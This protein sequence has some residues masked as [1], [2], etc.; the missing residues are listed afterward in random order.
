MSTDVALFDNGVKVPAYITNSAVGKAL[1]QQIAGGLD[2]Q[3]INRVALRNSKFRFMKSGAEVAVWDKPLEAVIVAANPHVGRI[4][5]AK[6]FD[7]NAA[8]ERPDCYSKD[9]RAPEDDSPNKQHDLCAT[10]PKNAKGSANNGVG[11][12]CAYKKRVIIAAPGAINGDKYALDLGAMTMFGD[13]LPAHKLYNFRSYLDVLAANGINPAGVITKFSFDDKATVAK[14][15]CTPVRPLTE[16]EWKQV[17]ATIGDP[18]IA[19]MLDDTDYA[20]EAGKPIAGAPAAVA[21]PA[22]A[23][24]EAPKPRAPRQTKAQQAAPAPAPEPQAAPSAP[25]GFGAPAA[26]PAATAPAG[27]G[28]PAPVAAAPAAPAGFGAPAAAPA[29]PAAGGFI[30]DVEEFED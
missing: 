12:A 10:C 17:E 1:A 6:P 7:Q 30:I 23:P 13:E 18:E 25:A 15:H 11:K 19:K 9:G 24:A 16:A 3:S 26:A 29:Q 5:Y 2:G 20:S 8:A 28:A 22:P 14:L 4:F 21:A 27:F